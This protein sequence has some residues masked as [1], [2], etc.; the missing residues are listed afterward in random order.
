MAVETSRMRVYRDNE[1]GRAAR[2]RDAER[3]RAL[4]CTVETAEWKNGWDGTP[5]CGLGYAGADDACAAFE[6]E[7]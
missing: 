2:E 5:E 3:A 4:G 1:A 7:G 6:R